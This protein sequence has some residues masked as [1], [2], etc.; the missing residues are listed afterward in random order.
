M[1]SH[2]LFSF[3]FL[4]CMFPS[5]L[6]SSSVSSFYLIKSAVDAFCC[7]FHFVLCTSVFNITSVSTFLIFFHFWS[8]LSFH[9]LAI[10]N[11]LS[12]SSHIFISLVSVTGTMLCPFSDVLFPWLFLILL[13]LHQYLITSL[14][15][16]VCPSIVSLLRY[17]G[18]NVLWSLSPYPSHFSTTGYLKPR[19]TTVSLVQATI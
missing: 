8:S 9:K 13:V 17:S 2:K 10:S 7:I 18:Q 3:F 16:L 5:S 14:C 15:S 19:N 11:S 12:S 1:L 6:S 4:S